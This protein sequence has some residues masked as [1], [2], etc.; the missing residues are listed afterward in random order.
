MEKDRDVL[1]CN[2]IFRSLLLR[3]LE[4]IFYEL[5]LLVSERKFMNGYIT[6]IMDLG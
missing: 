4:I 1:P 5:A 6:Y 2:D 3:D